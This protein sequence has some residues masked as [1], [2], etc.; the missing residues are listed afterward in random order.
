MVPPGAHWLLVSSL[1]AW[2]CTAAPLPAEEPAE[3]PKQRAPLVEV[4]VDPPV[5]QADTRIF[6]LNNI[7]LSAPESVLYEAESDNYLISNINGSP[8][9]RDNNG[10]ISRFLP[11]GRIVELKW[12]AGGHNGV[13]LNAP[14]GLAVNAGVLYVTDLDTVRAFDVKTGAPKF[15]VPIEGATFLNDLSV[16][17]EG[18]LYVSDSG[19]KENFEPSGS[20]AIYAIDSERKV[21]KLHSGAELGLPNGLLADATGTWVSSFGTGQLYHLGDDGTISQNQSLPKGQLDGIARWD[22]KR[23]LVASWECG[24]VYGGTPGGEFSEVVRDVPSPADI[25]FDAKHARLLVPQLLEDTLQAHA[26]AQ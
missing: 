12:I 23:V 25:H 15:E 21:E 26:L 9:S 1:L 11:D 2:G 5:T 18:K 20:A 14:K 7:G 8:F 6:D 13:T 3:Q 22:D 24:C 10:F 16:S 17:P 4:L 19:L